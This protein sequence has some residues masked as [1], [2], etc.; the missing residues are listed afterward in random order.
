MPDLNPTEV[1]EYLANLDDD[2]YTDLARRARAIDR[3][4][5]GI[6]LAL[7]VARSRGWN[8]TPGTPGHAG[9]I[10]SKRGN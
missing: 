6:D 7:E 4:T 3:T 5:S 8:A 1:E 9:V 2:E 10:P